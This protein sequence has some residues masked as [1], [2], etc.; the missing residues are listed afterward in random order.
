MTPL[1]SEPRPW[2]MR[3][4]LGAERADAWSRFNREA[5]AAASFPEKEQEETKRMGRVAPRGE[6]EKFH[7]RERR[8]RSPVFV[9]F[10]IICSNLWFVIF[11]GA[12]GA[13]RPASEELLRAQVVARA[14][15]LSRFSSGRVLVGGVYSMGS[16]RM[17]VA[18][19]PA[20]L[21]VALS[22]P[23]RSL[24]AS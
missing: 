1:R 5:G 15:S 4:L 22:E 17:K 8:K 20:P 12:R 16:S 7:R 18:P 13:T 3:S 2:R 24:A 6:T 10:V 11:G 19:L 14:S 9:I 21:L 23:P